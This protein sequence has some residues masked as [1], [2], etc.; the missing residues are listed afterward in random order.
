MP[1]VRSPRRTRRTRT[2]RYTL[3]DHLMLTGISGGGTYVVLHTFGVPVLPA[4]IPGLAVAAC[5][6]RRKLRT[7]EPPYRSAQRWAP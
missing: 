6:L 7:P 3:L 5:Y 4:A 1:R 2:R